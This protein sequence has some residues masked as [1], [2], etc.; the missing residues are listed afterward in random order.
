M[1]AAL[2]I[3]GAAS[4]AQKGNWLSA[5]LYGAGAA[6]GLLASGLDATGVGAVAGVPLGLL[7]GGLGL[8][9]MMTEGKPQAATGPSQAT[10]TNPMDVV[11][12]KTLEHYVAVQKANQKQIEL[13]SQ[14]ETAVNI[15]A[16]V[17]ARGHGDMIS[18]LKKSGNQIY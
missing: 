12:K 17:T 2:D 8:A 11:I 4:Q 9:G 6:T 13:L 7:S 16:N 3:A 18:Q 10:P 1:G 14:V 15:L 5:G